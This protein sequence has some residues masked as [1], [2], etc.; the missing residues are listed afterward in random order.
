[1][2]NWIFAILMLGVAIV[3]SM[4]A[5]FFKQIFRVLRRKKKKDPKLVTVMNA[6]Y[7]NQDFFGGNFNE[8]VSN[9]NTK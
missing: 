8:R 7:V 3:L 2:N 1:M 4:I 5:T 6:E 9:R